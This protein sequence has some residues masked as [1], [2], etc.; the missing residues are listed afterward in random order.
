LAP[1]LKYWHLAFELNTTETL[2][3]SVSAGL[4]LGCLSKLAAKDAIKSGRVS[5]LKTPIEMPR[6]FYLIIHK[7]KYRSP[8]IKNF[9]L[10]CKNWQQ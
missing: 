6:T 10:F 2:I 4:G 7:N 9:M 5:L 8:L 3:N 1:E